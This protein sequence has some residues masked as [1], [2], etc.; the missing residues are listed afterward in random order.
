M[1]FYMIRNDITKMRVDAIVN[2]ANSSLAPGGG[3]CGAIFAA[4]GHEKLRQECEAIGH[5]DV[6]NAVITRGFD[7]PAP[8]VIHAVGPIWQGGDHNE[9]QLLKNC[10]KN[11]LFLAEKHQCR[12][13]AFP[14]I[15]S[16]I[17]GYPKAAA[18]KCAMEAISDFLFDHDLEVTLVIFDKDS[19]DT[20]K[21]LFADIR[22][23]I[24]ERYIEE[25]P[26]AMRRRAE[27]AIHQ[28]QIREQCAFTEEKCC[29][30]PSLSIDAEPAPR[31][32][33]DLI[34]NAGETFSQML[35][36]L[37]EEKGI[38]DAEA[39]KRAHIDRRL[40]SKI[41]G[42]EHYTPGKNTVIAF[43]IALELNLDQT[44]DLLNTAGFSL[45]RSNVADIIVEYFITNKIYDIFEINET[46]FAFDQKILG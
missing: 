37:I 6:G 42:N 7:L 22:S 13:V 15:S 18:L 44:K 4:A 39:Y 46:L 11:A 24:D 20:S 23:Y 19:T 10:Y 32:L 14:L 9:E 29:A 38:T 16:G 8:Y 30:A 35:L 1:A 33:K 28:K 45:S 12:S 3:V 43:A 21:K 40:F 5:C 25:H 31:S 27:E 34:K 41:R 17:Y 2:A 36:R 26:I